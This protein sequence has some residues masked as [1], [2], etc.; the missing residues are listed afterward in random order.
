M[1]LEKIAWPLLE[2]DKVTARI[3]PGS[4]FYDMEMMMLPL[5]NNYRPAALKTIAWWSA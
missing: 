2:A 5:L 3:K 1:K 4:Y